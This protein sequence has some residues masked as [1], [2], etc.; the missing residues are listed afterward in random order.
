MQVQE[1]GQAGDRLTDGKG[2]GASGV[3]FF[4]MAHP[5][6]FSVQKANLFSGVPVAIHMHW[7]ML[8]LKWGRGMF[9]AAA[10]IFKNDH[11]GGVIF[12]S[13]LFVVAPLCLIKIK[14]L[15]KKIEEDR[16]CVILS[17]YSGR[18][19]RARAIK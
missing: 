19:S 5:P 16:E 11:G 18:F 8:F 7:G 4:C 3:L 6:Q 17:H 15:I 9:K 13:F 14:F 12:H 1:G 10:K 2:V